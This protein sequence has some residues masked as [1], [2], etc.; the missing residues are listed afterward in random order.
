MAITFYHVNWCPECA[1]VREKLAELGLDYEDVVVPDFRP[2]RKQ[3]YDVS[4]QHYVPVLKDGDKVLTE[5]QDILSYLDD[6]YGDRGARSEVRGSGEEGPSCS[7][8]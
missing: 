6:S 4:G 5:T 3:V 7:L 1:V 2:M 8:F